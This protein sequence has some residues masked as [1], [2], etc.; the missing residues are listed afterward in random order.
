VAHPSAR[1]VHRDPTPLLGGVATLVAFLAAILVLRWSGRFFITTPVFGFLAGG[2]LIFVMGLIDDRHDLSWFSKLLG[3]I[4]AAVLLLAS[5]NTVGPLSLTPLGLVLSLVWVVGLTNAMNFL[6]NM[7]GICAGIATVASAALGAL[8]LLSGQTETAILAFALTG[9]CL[10]FLRY[11]FP[12]ARIF[13]GDG[14]S[15]L[16]GYSLAALGL[17]ASRPM[18]LSYSL[19][20]PVVALSY[21]IFDITF[22]S[23]TRCARGQSLTEGGKDHSS[24]RL[25][26]VLGGAKST[27]LTIYG[28]CA[29]LGLV[30]VC[31]RQVASAPVTIVAF[32][33]VAMGFLAF[34]VRLARRAPVPDPAPPVRA[35]VS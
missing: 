14:G 9:S 18:E 4:V 28:L 3:Q 30:A 29:V 6:D 26:R 31:L 20:I 23:A 2:F 33:V 22:V 34:G 1:G 7:D 5:G 10:G 17:M 15:L 21:P 24:H 11:N 35:A 12:P 13:L 8:S 16:L 19:L 32:L 25:A 27:A